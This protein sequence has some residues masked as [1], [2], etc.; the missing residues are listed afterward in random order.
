TAGAPAVAAGDKSVAV[1]PFENL[2]DDKANAYFAEGIQDEILTKLAKVGALRVIARSSTQ[3]YAAHP[4]DLTE[5]ARRLGVANVL[6]G[7]VQKAGD[8]VHI[9]VQLIRAASGDHLWAETYDRKLDNVF[10]VES[11]VAQAIAQALQA[12]LSGGEQQSVAARATANAAAYEAYLRGLGHEARA[13]NAAVH[14]PVQQAVDAYAEAVRL[15]PDFALAWAHLSIMRS[16][17]YFNLLDRSPELLEAAR[18][19]ADTALKL[20]AD[21][22]EAYLAQGYYRY[23]GLR[24]YEGGLEYFHQALQR[25]PNSADVLAAIAYIERRQGKWRESTEHLEQA[26]RLDPLNIGKLSGLASN[27]ISLRQFPQAL[28]VDDRALAVTPQDPELLADKAM[29]Y[30]KM[31]DLDAADRVLAQ[32]PAGQDNPQVL[33]IRLQ[34]L[35]LQRRYQD[36]IELLQS[37]SRRT[38]DSPVAP[39]PWNDFRL[40]FL[41]IWAGHPESAH[42]PCATALDKLN[43]MRKSDADDVQL[44]EPYSAAYACL[45]NRAEALRYAS[46]A[47]ALNASDAL[48]RT[49]VEISQAMVQA[50]LGD[51]D[52]AL[53]VLPRLLHEPAGV[54]L[55]DLRLNPYWDSLRQEPRFRALLDGGGS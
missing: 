53:A 29:V 11:E 8:A 41:Q 36:A 19:A 24:D 43:H 12:Q 27:Y 40:G 51:R 39:D 18:Q 31:G 22:G 55:A 45:G 13:F 10:G 44:A 9:N 15:D 16:Y 34:Q 48:G 47:V 30:Q 5:I 20:H 35:W 37:R 23:W 25:L 42:A 1:L 46:M 14:E 52:N 32:L 26:T 33:E 38:A 54:T 28:E 49:E 4:A 6:E 3:Q 2:S 21:L 7:S 17:A 50:W